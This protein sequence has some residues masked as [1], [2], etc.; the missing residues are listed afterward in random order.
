MARG[1]HPTQTFSCT[2]LDPPPK[3]IDNQIRLLFN[4][5]VEVVPL[6]VRSKGKD[7]AEDDSYSDEQ[8]A[9]YDEEYRRSMTA[10]DSFQ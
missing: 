8:D 6:C 5:T 3:Y 2:A 10:A 9:E 1:V 4:V 7:N